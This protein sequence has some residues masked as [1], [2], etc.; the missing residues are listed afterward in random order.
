MNYFVKR[1][2]ESKIEGPF[3][4]DAINQMFKDK[5]L[6][7]NAMG[8]ADSGQGVQQVAQANENDWTNLIYI[9]GVNG[10]VPDCVEKRNTL[11]EKLVLGLIVLV[12]IL[13]LG[14]K[15][16]MNHFKDIQ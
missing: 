2:D 7:F 14:Y 9:Q 4:T 10:G 8:I 6:D 11:L 3:T 16:L 15:L 5:S 13:L 12:L 1:S